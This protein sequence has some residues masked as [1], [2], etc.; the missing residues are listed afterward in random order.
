MKT[1]KEHLKEFIKEVTSEVTNRLG[2]TSDFHYDRFGSEF[3]WA[4]LVVKILLSGSIHNFHFR[5]L[6][7]NDDNGNSTW[8]EFIGSDDFKEGTPEEF[9][10]EIEKAL[11]KMEKRIDN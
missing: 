1:L 4:G 8:D 5:I 2:T 10:K 7:Y 11:I 6:L 3:Q 9:A